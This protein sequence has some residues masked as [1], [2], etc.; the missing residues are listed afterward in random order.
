MVQTAHVETR[1][2]V[3]LGPPPCSVTRLALA[4]IANRDMDRLLSQNVSMN[5]ALIIVHGEYANGQAM[6]SCQKWVFSV[7]LVDD[8]IFSPTQPT[9]L[10]CFAT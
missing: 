3:A 9:S 1:I 8:P 7:N 4:A 6:M 10:C 5:E 2:V